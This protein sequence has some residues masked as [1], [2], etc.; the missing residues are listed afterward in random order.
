MNT[1]LNNPWV[2]EE[3]RKSFDLN[4][5]KNTTYENVWDAAK[6]VLKMKQFYMPILEK[7]KENISF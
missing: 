1:F 4:E 7:K 3:I 5:N 6:V 2:K